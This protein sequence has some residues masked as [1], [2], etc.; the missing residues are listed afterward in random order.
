MIYTKHNLCY[1]LTL[2]LFMGIGT[3]GKA[4]VLPF[5]NVAPLEE[6]DYF[7]KTVFSFNPTFMKSNK[8]MRILLQ[9]EE[10]IGMKYIYNFN[11]EGMI[12]SMTSI[13]YNNENVDTA[14]YTRYSYNLHGLTDKKARIDYSN[15]IV[16]V[17][18]YQY[19]KNNKVDIIRTFTLNA[20]MP[21]RSHNNDWQGEQVRGVDN[22]ILKGT[23]PDE[24]L[25]KKM[26]A[27][28]D[29]SSLQYRYYTENEF[30]AE[31]RT[32]Y[33]NF[34]KNSGNSDTCYQKKTYYYLKGHPAVLFLHHGCA[35]KKTPSELYQFKDGLLLQLSDAP[36]A[37]DPKTEEYVYDQNRN[38]KLMEDIWNGRK[39]SE[40]GMVYDE[41]GFLISIQRK[42][43]AAK[44]DYFEDRTLKVTY[45]FY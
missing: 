25:W 13:R 19:N 2:M 45:S 29:F 28:N 14:F 16:K 44:A 34:S 40:L 21:N 41:K 22:M 32:E 27:N 5:Y 24:S 31:E 15:G 39:V 38:L 18:S 30:E 37:V 8:V 10:K 35:V 23:F 26:T 4:Q 42:S 9:S 6:D 3:V 20:Q 12:V 17:S 1:C 43:D 36:A 7:T 33:F 11:P